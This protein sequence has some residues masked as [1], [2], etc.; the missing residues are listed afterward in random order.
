MHFFQ[1]LSAISIDCSSQWIDD[2]KQD[3]KEDTSWNKGQQ[4]LLTWMQSQN[5]LLLLVITIIWD[6]C[7]HLL[8]F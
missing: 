3:F 8:F 1:P 5:D 7:N 6:D 2:P 4:H